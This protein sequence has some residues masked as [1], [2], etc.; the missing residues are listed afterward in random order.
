MQMRINGAWKALVAMGCLVAFFGAIPAALAAQPCGDVLNDGKLSAS[1][2][3]AVLR[4]AVGQEVNLVCE[5]DCQQLLPRVAAVEALLAHLQVQGNNLVL[6]GMN[7]QVVNGSGATDGT[8]NGTGNIVIGY[9]EAGDND[10]KTG[11]HNLVIGM[12]HS[13]SSFGGL[14]AGG[15]NEISGEGA[16]VL[17]GTTHRV[18]GDYASISG[19]FRNEARGETSSIA[20]GEDNRTDGRSSVVS[21]GQDNFCGTQSAAVAG[22]SENAAMGLA[23]TVGGGRSRVATSA[24]DW[25]AGG[26]FQAE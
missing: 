20:G 22:G 7:F 18:S 6:T 24:F 4:A 10:K 3:L 16:T 5:A 8:V 11:S 12:E 15:N 9:N 25:W 23:S 14:V 13:Y 26:L 17:G 21:G 1:D 2:A 19:G